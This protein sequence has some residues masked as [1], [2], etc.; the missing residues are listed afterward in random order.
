MLESIHTKMVG[1]E[2]VGIVN[3]TYNKGALRSENM[4]RVGQTSA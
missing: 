2:K 4:L 3:E 1:I